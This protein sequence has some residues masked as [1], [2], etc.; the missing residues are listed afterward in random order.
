MLRAKSVFDNSF[1][2]VLNIHDLYRHLVHEQHFQSEFLSDMLRSEIVYIISAFDKFIHDIVKDGI[3]ETYNSLRVPTPAFNNF[4]INLS[5]MDSI[6]NPMP[7]ISPIDILENIIIENHKHLSFQ[8]PDKISQALSLVWL[9]N[10]KWQKIADH[11]SMN[12]NA[13]KIELKN[14]VIRRN[15]IV[16]EA[17]IDLFTNDIQV[18]NESD[19]S[20][21]VNFIKSLSDAI[22]NLIRLP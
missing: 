16:H 22:Y 19:V 2:R 3:L 5:Q 11:L 20:N 9:E 12:Q 13:L 15:Q 21:S 10:H 1:T 4:P 8:D 17:D 6:V 18:I 7:T 14:I